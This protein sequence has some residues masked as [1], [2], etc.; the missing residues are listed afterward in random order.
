MTEATAGKI[1]GAE[2]IEMKDIG[3]FP[4]SENYPVFR[5]YLVQALERIETRLAA[6]AGRA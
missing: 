4:M 3:H 1:K 6:P 5:E 2:F